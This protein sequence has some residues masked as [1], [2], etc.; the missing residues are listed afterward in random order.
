[1]EVAGLIPVCGLFLYYI[2]MCYGELYIFFNLMV[3]MKQEQKFRIKDIE[4][5]LLNISKHNGFDWSYWLIPMIK[6]YLETQNGSS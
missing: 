4:R 2:S 1:M 5:G 3:V 6:K